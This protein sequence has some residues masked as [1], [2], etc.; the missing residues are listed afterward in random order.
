MNSNDIAATTARFPPTVP[1]ATSSASSCL[2][3]SRASFSRSAYFLWS[4]NF[5]AVSYTHLP[6]TLTVDAFPNLKVTGTVD[7][8]APA[9]GQ[10]FALLPPDNATGNFTKIVQRIPVKII[11]NLTPATI[12][13]LRPGLSVE[14]T[15]NTRPEP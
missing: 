2:V 4:R 8:I 11:L 3:P 15:I 7:S 12:G 9:S 13:N 1:C 14:P 10:Q 5:N 6:V